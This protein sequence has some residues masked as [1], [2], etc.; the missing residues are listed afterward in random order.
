[1]MNKLDNLLNIFKDYGTAHCI[2]KIFNYIGLYHVST[3]KLNYN[4]ND[5][6]IFIISFNRLECLKKL[7]D[8][9]RSRDLLSRVIVID[10]NSTYKPL[11]K[12]LSTIE[13]EV[14]Y[15]NKN[16][17]HL[18]LWKCHIFDNHINNKPYI[19]TDC[20]VV[21]LNSI[22]NDFIE[23]MYMKLKDNQKLTKVGLSLLLDDIPFTNIKRAEIIEWEKQFWSKRMP[24]DNSLFDAKVDT[25]FAIYRPGIYPYLSQWWLS[26][27]TDAP[28]IARHYGWYIDSNNPSDEELYYLNSINKLS[29][30]WFG[31][32]SQF[33]ENK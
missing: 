30:H 29:S 1:M 17:G 31:K 18:A 21:P 3:S 33:N 7:I 15:L 26:A 24:N 14:I 4:V 13:C 28:Y 5:I 23:K 9:F 16:Y 6:K 27:R 20:D 25:T 2:K 19:L 8:F 11:L 12:Y 22:P 32:T 10:N